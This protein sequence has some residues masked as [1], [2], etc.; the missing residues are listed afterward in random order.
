MGVSWWGGQ[1]GTAEGGKRRGGR[2]EEGSGGAASWAGSTRG[3]KRQAMWSNRRYVGK[4]FATIRD[5]LIV[6]F[7]VYT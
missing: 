7:K 4:S 6:L 1:G 3:E 2:G 5:A